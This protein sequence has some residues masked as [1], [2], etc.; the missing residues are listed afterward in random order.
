ML[1]FN[2]PGLSV[3]ALKRFFDIPALWVDGEADIRMFTTVRNNE[4][5]VR[6]NL[7]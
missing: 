6:H 4:D 1:W 7:Y 3:R 5:F 2:T